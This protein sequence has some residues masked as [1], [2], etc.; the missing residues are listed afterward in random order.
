M[1]VIGFSLRPLRSL[2]SLTTL[3]VIGR[4]KKR[5][6]TLIGAAPLFNSHSPCPLA[7][8]RLSVASC[9]YSLRISNILI[10]AV[11]TGVPGPKIAAAPSL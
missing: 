8:W 11:A 5:S 2:K 9:Y 1:G 10:A 3:L 6:R 4:Q 7:T